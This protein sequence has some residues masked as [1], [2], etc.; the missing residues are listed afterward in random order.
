MNLLI[1]SKFCFVN[2]DVDTI[3]NVNNDINIQL[4]VDDV[5]AA[6]GNH[7][8]LCSRVGIDSLLNPANEDNFTKG[9]S[10]ESLVE[11]IVSESAA[12]PEKDQEDEETFTIREKCK[13][14]SFS[15]QIF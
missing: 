11:S 2:D 13:I 1:D 7:G 5:R 9:F 14:L 15:S 3:E 8:V 4:L 12:A 10:F 6:A